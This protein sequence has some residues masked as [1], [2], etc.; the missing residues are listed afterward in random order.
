MQAHFI[1]PRGFFISFSEII[2]NFQTSWVKV[3]ILTARIVFSA[4]W[5]SQQSGPSRSEPEVKILIVIYLPLKEDF[6][7]FTRLRFKEKKCVLYNL[8]EGD[9]FVANHPLAENK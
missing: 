8:T 2:Q 7:F 4:R 3:E 9:N 1:L 6:Q 5:H